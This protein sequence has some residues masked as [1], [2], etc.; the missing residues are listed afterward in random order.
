MESGR[1]KKINQNA[2]EDIQQRVS[3]ILVGKMSTIDIK[4]FFPAYIKGSKWGGGN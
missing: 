3:D 4:K 1:Y 2:F